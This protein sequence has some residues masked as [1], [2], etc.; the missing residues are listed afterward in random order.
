VHLSLNSSSSFI[1]QSSYMKQDFADDISLLKD[2]QKDLCSW[3]CATFEKKKLP[4]G[5]YDELNALCNKLAIIIDRTETR[6][7]TR[8]NS[9]VDFSSR[10]ANI[11]ESVLKLTSEVAKGHGSKLSFAEAVQLPSR[12]TTINSSEKQEMTLKKISAKEQVVIVRPKVMKGSENETR[13]IVKKSVKQV[14]KNEKSARVKK[15]VNVRGGGVLL[16]LDPEENKSAIKNKIS[17]NE[18]LMVSEP[19]NKKP[20]VIIY[21]VSKELSP[22]DIREE[23]YNRNLKDQKLDETNFK[24]LFKIGSRGRDNV[25]WVVECSPMI[26]K[27]LINKNRIYIEWSACRIKDYI[28]VTRCYKCQ[29]FHHLSKWCK[30]ENSTCAHCATEGHDIKECPNRSKKPVCYHCKKMKKD[31]GHRVGDPTCPSY[32]RALQKIIDKTDYGV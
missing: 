27:E 3:G 31:D 1:E 30:A 20:K 29:N 24:P 18:N 26:R 8:V 22:V 2:I 4:R 6:Y 21:N 15:T 9:N 17:N 23:V 5:D 13:E 12:K 11:E 28:A 25:H 14:I 19:V 10:L 32:I 16:V 7:Y